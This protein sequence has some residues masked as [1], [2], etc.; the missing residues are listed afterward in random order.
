[1]RRWSTPA[2]SAQDVT[3]TFD[4]TG[5]AAG[6]YT[7]DLCIFSND[8]DPGPG[9]GTNLAPVP[10]TLIVQTPTAVTLSGL[11]A[12][13]SPSAIP[14]GLP[15]TAFPAAAGLAMAAVYALRRRR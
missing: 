12:T 1:M 9:N 15:L 14:T 2:G 3:V 11:G 7:G 8:P 4:S 5:L 6:T 10:V 13:E